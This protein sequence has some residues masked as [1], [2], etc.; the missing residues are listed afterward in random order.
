M[1]S[2]AINQNLDWRTIAVFMNSFRSRSAST[3]ARA[4][5]SSASIRIQ[6]G[7]RGGIGGDVSQIETEIWRTRGTRSAELAEL[8]LTPVHRRVIEGWGNSSEVRRHV[9]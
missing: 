6:S 4:V 2:P 5:K 7:I 9:G 1:A 8:L 3:Q